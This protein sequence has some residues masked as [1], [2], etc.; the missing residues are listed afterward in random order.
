MAG[1]LVTRLPV[2]VG[3]LAVILFDDSSHNCHAYLL[4]PAQDQ[5]FISGVMMMQQPMGKQ[6]LGIAGSG[7]C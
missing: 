7:Q 1:P 3:W 6:G 4:A 5:M 2:I